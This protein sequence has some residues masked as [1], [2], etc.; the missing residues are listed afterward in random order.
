MLI[1]MPNIRMKGG[2]SMG[3]M[4]KY[5]FYAFILVAIY[6]IGMGVYEGAITDDTTVG[7]VG[8]EVEQGTKRLIRDGYNATDRMIRQDSKSAVKASTKS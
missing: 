2:L 5:L 7:Q 4:F 8:D 6:L 3:T 1:F